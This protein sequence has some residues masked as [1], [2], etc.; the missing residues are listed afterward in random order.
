MAA[1]LRRHDTRDKR[2]ERLEGECTRLK[3]ENERL[4]EHMQLLPPESFLAMYLLLYEDAYLT[5]QF[6][7]E[8]RADYQKPGEGKVPIR[9]FR[10]HRMKVNVDKQL[11]R[12]KYQ[13]VQYLEEGKPIPDPERRKSQDGS[14]ENIGC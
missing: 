4:R 6:H 7:P 14:K 2:I 1:A 3:R 11:Y 9:N 13:M 12:L 8:V 10:S 5:S